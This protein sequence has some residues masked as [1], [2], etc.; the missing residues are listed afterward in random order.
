VISLTLDDPTDKKAIAAAEKFLQEKKAVFLNVLLDE[1]FGDG[2]DRLNISAIPAVFL[3]DSD[4][5]EVKRYTMDD[6]DHQFTYEQVE[7]EV[8][9]LLAGGSPAG[10]AK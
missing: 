4:G 1:N 9:A 2:F 8:S 3:F 10:A 7:K 5:K 6:P